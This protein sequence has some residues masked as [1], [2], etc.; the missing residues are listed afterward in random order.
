MKSLKRIKS[1]GMYNKSKHKG[2]RIL[3]IPM[4]K[5]TGYFTNTQK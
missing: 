1:H 5:A 3:K 2:K 4:M